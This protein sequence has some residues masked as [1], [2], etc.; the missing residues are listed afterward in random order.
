MKEIYN[1]QEKL[2]EKILQYMSD[3]TEAIPMDRLYDRFCCEWTHDQ[4]FYKIREVHA[5]TLELISSGGLVFCDRMYIATPR[6]HKVLEAEKGEEYREGEIIAEYYYDA[7]YSGASSL[8]NLWL[9]TRDFNEGMM[10]KMVK[11]AHNEKYEPAPCV[12]RLLEKG[13]FIKE[14]NYRIVYNKYR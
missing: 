3:L 5:A 7:D 9:V 4:D 6:L 1:K 10:R 12:F 2:K 14:V 13:G 8:D 11:M